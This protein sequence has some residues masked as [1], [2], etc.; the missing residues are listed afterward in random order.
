MNAP[1]P[2]A[3]KSTADYAAVA[4]APILIFLMISSLANFL[5]LIVYHGYQPGRVSW[6]LL[7]FTMGAVGIARVAIEKDR[8]YSLGYAGIL[9]IA[10][11]ITMVRFVD[12]PIFVAMILGL[13]AYLADRIVRD[14]TL[15][16]EDVDSSDQGLLDSGRFFQ[17][18]LPADADDSKASLRKPVASQ[19]GRTVLY[20]A[21][22]ALPM[23][24]LGQFLL[25]SDPET[26]SRAQKLLAFYLF[27]SLSLLVTT[28]FLGLRRYLRQRKVEMPADV[29][30]AWIG[31]GLA[32]IGV[33]LFI[34]FL[35]PVPGQMLASI[36]LPTFLDSP[37]DTVASKSGWG[38]DGADKK[39]D[40]AATT[41]DDK[42]GG[43]KETEGMT[44]GKDAPAG[45]VGDGERKSG[46]PG[47]QPGGDKGSPGDGKSD[48]QKPDP[49]QKAEG[50][51]GKDGTKKEEGAKETNKIEESSDSSKSPKSDE[52]PPSEANAPPENAQQDQKQQEQKQTPQQQQ[53]S[54]AN[55]GNA[56]KPTPQSSLSDAMPSLSGLLKSIVL[57]VLAGIVAAFVWIH[58][59][60][61]AEWW[62]HLFQNDAPE[63]AASSEEEWVDAQSRVPPRPF[64][65]YQNP[66]GRES[67]PRRIVTVT[68]AAWEAW[69]RERGHSRQPDETPSE[70]LQ[71]TR[72]VQSAAEAAASVV[73]AYNRIA[74]G[75]GRASDADV[76]AAD[77]LWRSML[78]APRTVPTLSA[79]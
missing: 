1:K 17:P 25:R 45:D 24:G 59:E 63:T 44:A 39:T 42:T 29:S 22:A 62:R 10:A 26:W 52:P 61:I 67:D 35:A 60:A 13:I 77:Q 68:F 12:S 79:S 47:K 31:G 49:S 74:Y 16:D 69:C 46:P 70:F 57:L 54:G 48:Q 64:S 4:V 28:S 55:S 41:G 73:D 8:A 78:D 40:G 36:E 7:M 34:A 43:E 11:F 20:L 5:M 15:I 72:S 53:N 18:R 51:K 21:L 9:G 14:C 6:T 32:L 30:V 75:R 56:P 33:I 27:S 65:S 76:A 66:I 19:P 58:R 23:F 2:P 38:D 37:G 50:S 71:R 3:T